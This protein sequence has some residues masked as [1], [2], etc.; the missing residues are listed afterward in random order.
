MLGTT[1]AIHTLEGGPLRL[2]SPGSL[3]ASASFQR[4]SSAMGLGAD[5]QS[6]SSMAPD[7]PRHPGTARRLLIE[8]ART[9]TIRN[10]GFEGG[11]SPTYMTG[12]GGTGNGLTRTILGS[13]NWRGLPYIDLAITG[14][15]ATAT[16]LT[17]SFESA[18]IVASSGQSWAFSLFL[19]LMSGS[20]ANYVTTL[21]IRPRDA[22]NNDV[23]GTGFYGETIV[24]PDMMTRFVMSATMNQAATA[25]LTPNL[26]L[27]VAQGT[28]CNEVIRLAVPQAEL[29]SFASTPILPP[30]GSLAAAS[31]AADAAT[32][33]L[34][35]AQ[36]QRGTLVG[37]FMIPQAA[38]ADVQ[39][40]LSMDPGNG[41]NRISIQN[42]SNG[43]T[44][45]GLTITGGTTTNTPVLTTVTPGVPFKAAIAWDASGVAFCAAGGA[46]SWIAGLPPMDRLR[47]GND[48]F[49]Q[50]AMFGEVGPLDLHGARLPDAALQALTTSL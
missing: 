28:V 34:T 30:A 1:P 24:L 10:P 33:M 45:R 31:R 22:S 44:V 4:A 11:A 14:T 3:L 50:R 42:N 19:A 9:N 41:N 13:G 36:Q 46:V 25:N 38:A 39:A 18:G 43:S 16:V 47:I 29:G 27:S 35:A 6:W 2:V 40:L 49:G 12:F 23:N 37:T 17:L 8:G 5:G 32:L 48:V 21:N 26:R 7:V 20:A 15:A